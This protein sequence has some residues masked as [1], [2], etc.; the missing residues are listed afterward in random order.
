MKVFVGKPQTTTAK[1]LALLLL[2]KRNMPF[3]LSA[4][5]PLT[6]TCPQPRST[7]GSD[8]PPPR[9]RGEKPMSRNL[10]RT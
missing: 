9:W 4:Q 5:Q 2:L 10:L 8:S 7:S 1:K 6:S 3:F